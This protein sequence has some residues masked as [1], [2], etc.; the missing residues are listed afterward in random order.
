M[1]RSPQYQDF[2]VRCVEPCKISLF[3]AAARLLFCLRGG[4]LAPLAE[5]AAATLLAA[6]AAAPPSFPLVVTLLNQFPLALSPNLMSEIYK[7]KLSLLQ[8]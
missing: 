6:G 5:N 7:S 1:S 2:V 8:L 3:T 4:K